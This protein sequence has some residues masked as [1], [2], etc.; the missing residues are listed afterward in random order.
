MRKIDQ[1]E[2]NNFTA[3]TTKEEYLNTLKTCEIETLV[4]TM[5][6]YSLRAPQPDY[7]QF[8]L[9]VKCIG[10]YQEMN[11]LFDEKF[12]LKKL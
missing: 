9:D 12:N 8:I 10:R 7:L 2:D 1:I 5:I 4:S 11:D 3:P 6:V